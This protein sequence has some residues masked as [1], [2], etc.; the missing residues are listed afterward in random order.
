MGYPSET[1]IKPGRNDTTEKSGHI[2]GVRLRLEIDLIFDFDDFSLGAGELN[3]GPDGD[4]IG[5]RLIGG[6]HGCA[7]CRLLR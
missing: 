2:R 5:S 1:R 6:F 3:V 4:D 7:V